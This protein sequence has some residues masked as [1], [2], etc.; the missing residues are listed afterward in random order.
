MKQALFLETYNRKETIYLKKLPV[1]T[2]KFWTLN[3]D[4]K[5]WNSKAGGV[6][7]NLL[8]LKS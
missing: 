7:K 6:K 4:Y 3:K 2:V 8:I 1:S 5:K